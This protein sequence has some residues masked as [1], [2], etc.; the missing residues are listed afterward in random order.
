MRYNGITC[1][2]DVMLA[3]SWGKN[4]TLSMAWR[5]TTAIS[6]GLF[7]ATPNPRWHTTLMMNSL[8]LGADMTLATQEMVKPLSSLTGMYHAYWTF[9]WKIY[10]PNK[11]LDFLACCN[12]A[13]NWECKIE[14]LSFDFEN[15]KSWDGLLVHLKFLL[16]AIWPHLV[17]CVVEF[18]QYR[19]FCKFKIS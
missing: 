12:Y 6:F 1:K 4:M 10:F 7:M 15:S 5:I 17:E 16:N 3:D 13:M 19:R 2:V 8:K 9:V 14:Q 18:L 11:S